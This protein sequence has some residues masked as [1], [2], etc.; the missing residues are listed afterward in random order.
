MAHNRYLCHKT[1]LIIALSE[2][3]EISSN[4]IV[5][6]QLTIDRVPSTLNG[7]PSYRSLDYE[8]SSQQ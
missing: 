5:K 3:S 4:E 6:M 1:V 8:M 7:Y 2:C